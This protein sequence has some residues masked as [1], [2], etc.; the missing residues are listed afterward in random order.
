M[1]WISTT[2]VVSVTLGTG[3]TGL[4]QMMLMVTWTSWLTDAA[5]SSKAKPLPGAIQNR[6]ARPKIKRLEMGG[7]I[8][9][10]PNDHLCLL[11]LLVCA[12]AVT[13]KTVYSFSDSKFT[14][15]HSPRSFPIKSVHAQRC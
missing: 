1:K 6:V 3:S 8:K 15:R 5:A 9:R 12:L 14:V 13:Y 4:G 7:E 10:N 11:C 2:V